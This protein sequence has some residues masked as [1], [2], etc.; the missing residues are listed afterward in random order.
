MSE[1]QTVEVEKKKTRWRPT[2]HVWELPYQY[3]FHGW[4]S[5]V[6]NLF[7]QTIF[8]T[9]WR[10]DDVRYNV[11]NNWTHWSPLHILICTTYFHMAVVIDNTV[12][13]LLDA[14]VTICFSQAVDPVLIEA[15]LEARHLFPFIAGT[16]ATHYLTE[17][18]FLHPYTGYICRKLSLSITNI[19]QYYRPR[20]L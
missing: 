12:F 10:G 5:S 14:R 8:P 6:P 18:Q 4:R 9:P 2:E 19:S 20:V 11:R 16:M 3:V 15:V 7:C 13:H 17:S 1:V